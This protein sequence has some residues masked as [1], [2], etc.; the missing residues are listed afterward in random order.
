MKKNPV[1][2]A[3]TVL[4]FFGWMTVL[5]YEALRKSKPIV[6]SRAQMMLSQYEVEVDLE[7]PP[8][9]AKPE[10]VKISRVL[11][12]ADE[13]PPSGE[14][15]IANLGQTQGYAGPGAYL[16]PLVRNGAKYEVAGYPLDPGYPLSKDPPKPRIYPLTEEV[17]QQHR[18]IRS[19]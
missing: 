12:K 5:G 11:Y 1:V 15:T 17:R 4:L 18:Q 2:L 16:I 10:K 6:V 3:I 9:A 8:T 19:F 13:K 7:S 14:I